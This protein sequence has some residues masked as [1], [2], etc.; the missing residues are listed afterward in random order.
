MCACVWTSMW[1]SSLLSHSPLWDSLS[2]NLE[3][4]FGCA[5][6]LVNSRELL[7]WDFP[8]L[9]LQHVA[10]TW[11]LRTELRWPCLGGKHNTYLAI[12]PSPMKGTSNR[13][14]SNTP[15]ICNIDDLATLKLPS[16]SPRGTSSECGLSGLRLDWRVL[17]DLW[18][19]DWFTL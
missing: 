15:F 8:E 10:F 4:W 2:L 5:F 16:P 14:D 18:I 6:W 1:R 17:S 3:L 9:V 11:V 13:N 12:F 19:C 7:V